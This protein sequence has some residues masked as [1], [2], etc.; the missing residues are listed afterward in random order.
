M[1]PDLF[2]LSGKRALVTGGGRGLGFEIAKVLAL[3]G[4]SVQINGRDQERLEEAVARICEGGG[5]A[6][7]L[8]FDVTDQDSISN[9]FQDV[10]SSP[11]ILV[12]N[13][14][15]RNR[16]PLQELSP[17][18]VRAML[19]A[20]LVAAFEFSRQSARA[21]AVKGWGRIINI[22]S[23][24]GPR[25][26]AGDAAY[27]ASKGGLEALT[28]ALAAELGPDGITVN[29]ISPGYFAT[30]TNANMVDD[31]DVIAFLCGHSALGRWGRPDEI[32][33]AALFLASD[34]ASY[35]TGQVITVDGGMTSLF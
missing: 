10:E 2:S 12:N 18:D 14:G 15:A 5:E 19:E 20:N 22:T 21:M 30:E 4:A 3:A 32:A 16:R 34:A 17:S 1:I 27:T 11:D 29:A 7:A 28:R 6:S 13:V 24:A 31:P 23:I 9:F 26:R 25:A 35:V 33:G 8:A